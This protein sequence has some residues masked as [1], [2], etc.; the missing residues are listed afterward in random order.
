MLRVNLQ[1]D[2]NSSLSSVLNQ[3][4]QSRKFGCIIR[5][6]YSTDNGTTW[7]DVAMTV[8]SGNTYECDIGAFPG[9]TPLHEMVGQG[10]FI[11]MKPLAIVGELKTLS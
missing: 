2:N 8:V 5:T 3:I 4:L 10:G 11:P 1:E 9:G 7:T 6:C